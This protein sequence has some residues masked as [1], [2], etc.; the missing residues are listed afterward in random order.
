MCTFFFLE[1]TPAYQENPFQQ[2]NLQNLAE[3]TK[4]S[5]ISALAFANE[6]KSEI[7]IGRHQNRVQVHSVR[8]EQQQYTIDFEHAPIV[9]L[10]RYDNS[11]VAGFANG[12][13]QCL[14]VN[15]EGVDSTVEGFTLDKVGDD[16]SHLRQ[17]PVERNLVA[18]G[19]K[20]RQ[21]NLKVLDMA[22]EGKQLF[23]SKNLPNDYLQLEVPVW[24]SDVG[25]ID[26]PHVLATCS[27]YGYVRVYDTR[28]Q[29]RPVQ[30]FATEDQ[31]SFTSLA[32]RGN[33]IY[34]GTTMGAMKVRLLDYI[35]KIL[36]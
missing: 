21:N 4:E 8:T 30:L 18:I 27:R 29:R 26:S 10:A 24:D 1:L 34:T 3:L 25:F 11:I 7:L 28:K 13:I 36:Q 33:Y 19:G 14:A 2:K 15:D 6:N 31:M 16:M 12:K 35:L 22:A 20:G 23:S 5:R 17:C 32:A 9:G